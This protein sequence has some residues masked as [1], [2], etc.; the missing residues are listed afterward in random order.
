MG[1]MAAEMF[2]MYREMFSSWEAFLG[3]KQS[4][5]TLTCLKSLMIQV[6]VHKLPRRSDSNNFLV[7]KLCA[8]NHKAGCTCRNLNTVQSVLTLQLYLYIC[9]LCSVAAAGPSVPQLCPGELLLNKMC[10][11]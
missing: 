1:D 7:K 11:A 3:W 8:V 2:N 4:E 6:F 10:S 5:V 9:T